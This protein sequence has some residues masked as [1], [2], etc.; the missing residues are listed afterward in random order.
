MNSIAFPNY[1]Q[2]GIWLKNTSGG[3]C[4]PDNRTNIIELT[5]QG[6]D[7]SN[8]VLIRSS[9]WGHTFCWQGDCTPSVCS[10][11]YGVRHTHSIYAE[12]L[13]QSYDIF[14]PATCF[15]DHPAAGAGQVQ[16]RARVDGGGAE[17]G[18]VI[19]TA[20]DRSRAQPPACAYSPY[21]NLRASTTEVLAI[22]YNFPIKVLSKV[23]FT[24]PEDPVGCALPAWDAY[25]VQIRKRGTNPETGQ[26]YLWSILGTTWAIADCWRTND[27]HRCSVDLYWYHSGASRPPRL[28]IPPDV[29]V[30]LP[31]WV[32]A[33]MARYHYPD[34]I[35]AGEWAE[36]RLRYNLDGDYSTGTAGQEFLTDPI[37]VVVGE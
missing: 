3:D 35:H 16:I 27:G 31:D 33:A 25:R 24:V 29:L 20:F 21:V 6:A 2:G 14:L 1:E 12:G 28:E 9:Q 18:P 4:G 15:G 32:P 22:E 10:G 23:T 19:T 7:W 11:S 30:K 5:T 34:F 13:F 8:A 26:P 36:V 37:T 17:W